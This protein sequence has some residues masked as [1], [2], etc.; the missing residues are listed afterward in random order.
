MKFPMEYTFSA[1]EGM[2][3]MVVTGCDV[4]DIAAHITWQIHYIYG[5]LK[6]TNPEAAKELRE[7]LV[8][9]VSD[10]TSPC[11]ED[12]QDTPGATEICFTVPKEDTPL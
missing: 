4:L 11:W 3:K 8:Q 7:W 6:E 12:V 5:K 2:P 10:P 1:K 9:I